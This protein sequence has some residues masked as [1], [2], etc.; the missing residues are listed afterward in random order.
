ALLLLPPVHLPRDEE[1]ARRLEGHLRRRVRECLVGERGRARDVSL[2][3]QN[4]GAS[5]PGGGQRGTSTVEQSVALDHCREPLGPVE[6]AQRY[7]RLDLVGKERR[8]ERVA[9]ALELRHQRDRLEQSARA[10]GVAHGEGQE[11]RRPG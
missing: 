10:G 9:A 8:G 6:L 4:E 1:R 7:E 11:G 3:C 5:T 2:C